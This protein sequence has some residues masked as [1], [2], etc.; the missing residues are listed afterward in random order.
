MNAF[1][2]PVHLLNYIH[3][4][5]TGQFLV[6]IKQSFSDRVTLIYEDSINVF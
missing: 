2:F 3:L 5:I 6:T 4:T 1:L